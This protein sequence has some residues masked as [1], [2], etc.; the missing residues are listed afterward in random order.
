MSSNSSVFRMWEDSEASSD[1]T[2]AEPTGVIK[3]VGSS[4]N[5][6]TTTN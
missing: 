3:V 4:G 6:D 1:R 5:L 2:E